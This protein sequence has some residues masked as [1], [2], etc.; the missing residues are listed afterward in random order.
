M[1]QAANGER[2]E[3]ACSPGHRAPSTETSKNR[4]YV[5]A[6]TQS[7]KHKKKH[8]P[9]MHGSEVSHAKFLVQMKA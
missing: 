9:S 2:G 3:G 5:P 4:G 7:S 8:K 1:T 6:F